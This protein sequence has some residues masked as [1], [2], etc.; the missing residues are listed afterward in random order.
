MDEED[1]DELYPADDLYP[2]DELFPGGVPVDTA[3][4]VIV[5]D[6]G[7]PLLPGSYVYQG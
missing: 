7:L 6:N 2:D 3:G 1:T 4:Q 5:V